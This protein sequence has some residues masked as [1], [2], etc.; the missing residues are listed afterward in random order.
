MACPN[1][2]RQHTGKEFPVRPVVLFP[3]WFVEPFPKG[4]LV[5]VLNPEALP[6]F[7]EHEPNRI[8][9][10]DLHLAAYHLARYIRAHAQG[11]GPK[12]P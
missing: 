12:T 6:S 9:E 1:A 3:G 8:N 4:S 2:S 11:F 5:W 10:S 7:I